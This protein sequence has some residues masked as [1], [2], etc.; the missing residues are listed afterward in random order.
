MSKSNVSVPD[1]EDSA[2]PAE[3]APRQ[4]RTRDSLDRIRRA[5]AEILVGEGPGQFSMAAVAE[6]A[7]VSVT[8]IYRRFENKDD[9]VLDTKRDV[10]RQLGDQLAAAVE[11]AGAEVDDAIR[12]YAVRLV[13]ELEGRQELMR[14]LIAPTNSVE[15]RSVGA[16][17][18]ERT[19][20][21]LVDAVMARVGQPTARVK[22]AATTA[23]ETVTFVPLYRVTMGYGDDDRVEHT[24]HL[25]SMAS[26]LVRASLPDVR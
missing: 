24:E 3:L 25:I 12:A 19:R 10:L 14:V 5:A 4:R 1:A 18:L 23:W 7:G 17:M 16:A 6:R 13:A 22:S 26:G 9:L 20:G 15:I 11:T 8:A 21:I 2:R